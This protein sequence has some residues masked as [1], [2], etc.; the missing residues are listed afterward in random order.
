M[1]VVLV[2]VVVQCK[3]A[4]ELQRMIWDKVGWWRWWWWWGGG[5]GVDDGDCGSGGGVV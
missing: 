5:E 3:R 1:I 4:T 2:L